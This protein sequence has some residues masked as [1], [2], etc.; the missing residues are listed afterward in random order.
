M[1]PLAI[2]IDLIR[3]GFKPLP[4]PVGEKGPR[5]PEWQHLTITAEN[6]ERYFNGA[7][8]NVGAQMG[9]MSN[10]LT[11]VDLD[12]AEAVRLAPYFLPP[13]NSKYGR[14]SKRKSHYLYRCPDPVDKACIQLKDETQAM[15]VELRLGGGG[16]GSQSV[17]PGSVH[18]SGEH[19]AW[20]E[21]GAQATA[22]CEVRHP[23]RS[24]LAGGRPPRGRHEGRRHLGS[25]WM[26]RGQRRSVHGGG[27]SGG[28]SR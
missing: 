17:M 28:R 27:P 12:C 3:R 6:V 4:I 21:D 7:A 13:T 10:G 20:D 11:D 26:G 9:P 5:L 1:T 24:S 14:P 25:R 18:T 15:I 19:Y 22:A 8:L 2:A 23:A 16:K